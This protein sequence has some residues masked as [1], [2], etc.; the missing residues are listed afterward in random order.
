MLSK[1]SVEQ[2]LRENLPVPPEANAIF[3][4]FST[5]DKELVQQRFAF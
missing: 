4:I 3:P 1:L 5:S 2:I